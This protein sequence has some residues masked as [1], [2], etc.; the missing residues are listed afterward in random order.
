MRTLYFGISAF[1]TATGLLPLPA[2]AQ[3]NGTTDRSNI[4]RSAVV[5]PAGPIA[6]GGPWN[7]FSFSGPGSNAKGCAPADPAGAACAPSSA[8]NSQFIGVPPWTFTAPSD[9]ASLTV[10]DAFLA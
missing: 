9:G 1:V 7:E 8:G 3:E 2:V 5:A 10:T 4:P 6:T